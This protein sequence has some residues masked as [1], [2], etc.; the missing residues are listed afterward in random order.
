MLC[1]NCIRRFKAKYT[2]GLKTELCIIAGVAEHEYQVYACPRQL[3]HAFF[4]Q[5]ATDAR[6]LQPS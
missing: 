1:R 5:R 4:N 6:A 3:I 2:R